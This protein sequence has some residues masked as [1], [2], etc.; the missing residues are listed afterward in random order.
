MSV[1]DRLLVAFVLLWVALTVAFFWAGLPVWGWLWIAILLSV[2]VAEGVSIL[3]SGR[4]IT[5]RWQAWAK[6]HRV[7]AGF[8]LVGM[9]TAWGFLLLHLVTP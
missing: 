4:T 5:Q 7:Q 6:Q 9:A 1:S 8:V 3:R 2:V